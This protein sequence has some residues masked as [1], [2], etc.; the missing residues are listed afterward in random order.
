[1]AEVAPVVYAFYGNIDVP[2]AEAL[3]IQ[4]AL[5]TP[6]TAGEQRLRTF[7]W[8]ADLIGA[9]LP[10]IF[11]VSPFPHPCVTAAGAAGDRLQF[12]VDGAGWLP[13]DLPGVLH[14]LAER[15]ATGQITYT[16]DGAA[17][18]TL[19]TLADGQVWETPVTLGRA[20]AQPFPG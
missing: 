19:L 8:G 18:S 10:D 2:A 14:L 20:P 16:V 11:D 1:M 7:E 4:E 9:T 12:A 17:E 5:T 3:N 6:P 13:T 15:G